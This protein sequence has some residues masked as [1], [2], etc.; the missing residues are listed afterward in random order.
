MDS[1]VDNE[2]IKSDKCPAYLRVLTAGRFYNLCVKISF[3]G[4][5]EG[6]NCEDLCIE[7]SKIIIESED[8]I[9]E[10]IPHVDNV[11]LLRSE[12]TNFY[13]IGKAAKV[14]ERM[15]TFKTGNP[16][17]VNLICFACCPGDLKV[18]RTLQ[19]KFDKFRNKKEGPGN[20][21]FT[22]KR[23]DLKLVLAEYMKIRSQ[24]RYNQR[25][26]VDVI[27]EDICESEDEV[28]GKEEKNVPFT[29]DPKEVSPLSLG[30]IIE[31]NKGSKWITPE[32][33]RKFSELLPLCG[34]MPVNGS[35]N[36]G[37][38]CGRIAI[39]MFEE[40]NPAK[41][42]CNETSLCKGKGKEYISTE[43]KG[44]SSFMSTIS[45]LYLDRFKCIVSNNRIWDFK[46]ILY[47]KDNVCF[48]NFFDYSKNGVGVD[49]LHDLHFSDDYRLISIGKNIRVEYTPSTK[50]GYLM[51]GKKK[52][53]IIH[54]E[55]L[56]KDTHFHSMESDGT[57]TLLIEDTDKTMIWDLIKK[58]PVTTLS[59]KSTNSICFE[60]DKI[61]GLT[62]LFCY[63]AEKNEIWD[64]GTKMCILSFKGQLL[65]NDE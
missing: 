20:E 29:F 61:R 5:F 27:E 57:Y 26:G 53:Y 14:S 3:T 42:R 44:L 65:Q 63:S 37:K 6:I 33:H 52:S 35:S 22:F 16:P 51:E 11:Y 48:T 38:I 8:K 41:W 47:K 60:V 40:N 62:L 30:Y 15:N 2:D 45:P 49:K 10:P 1:L 18:E 64:L 23:K 4:N 34:Y 39:N 59:R 12:G 55:K 32:E 31:F 28:K 9:D 7:G 58:E 24:Y 21:W 56:T 43:N 36:A 50:E 46:G 54:I 19:K 17:N 25:M 13:K